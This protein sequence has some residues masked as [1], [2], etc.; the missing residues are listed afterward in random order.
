MSKS[1]TIFESIYS[2]LQEIGILDEKG[3]MQVNYMKFKSEGLM[4]LNVDKMDLFAS[5]VNYI[6]L[7][8][9]GILNGDVMDDPRI[10]IMIDP[11]QKSAI[12]YMLKNDRTY[13]LEMPKK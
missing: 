3:M 1:K 5:S 12:G 11:K 6:S 8:H 4:D 7:A 2:K 9:N 10:N 13:A